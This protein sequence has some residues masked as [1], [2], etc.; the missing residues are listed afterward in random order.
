MARWLELDPAAA[1]EWVGVLP[2]QGQR[3]DLM[4]EFFHSMGL[5]DPA[6]ALTFLAQYNAGPNRGFASLKVFT[7]LNTFC[8]ALVASIA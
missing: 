3:M 8:C 6:T 1:Y 2:K 7:L 5:R 4:R